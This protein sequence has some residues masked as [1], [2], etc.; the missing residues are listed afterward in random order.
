MER[1]SSYSLGMTAWRRYAAIFAL[2]ALML[3][4]FVPVG[5]MP[6]AQAFTGGAPIVVCTLTGE[7]HIVLDADG[8]PL[9]DGQQQESDSDQAPCAFA[10]VASLAPPAA[11][12]AIVPTLTEA[13]SAVAFDRIVAARPAPKTAWQSRAPPSDLSVV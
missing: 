6:S 13:S 7:K 11:T 9:P 4:A 1:K 12:I 3:R 2:T 8:K 10:A 5:W